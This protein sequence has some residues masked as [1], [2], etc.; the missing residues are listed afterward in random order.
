MLDA[1]SL[2]YY[3]RYKNT[4]YSNRSLS[5]VGCLSG[6]ADKYR[7]NKQIGYIATLADLNRNKWQPPQLV[8]WRRTWW[9]IGR[10]HVLDTF[11]RPEQHRRQYVW[12]TW[13]QTAINQADN[14]IVRL[15]HWIVLGLPYNKQCDIVHIVTVN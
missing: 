1:Q 7:E 5:Q 6:T 8:R 13:R 9:R 10:A 4:S 2:I 14:Y 12:Q 3:G 15:L 11:H